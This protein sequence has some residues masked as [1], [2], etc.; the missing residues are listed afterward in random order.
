[1]TKK[2]LIEKFTFK[3]A[4]KLKSRK[5]IELLFKEGKSFSNF[6]FRV[7]YLFP[8]KNI[9]PLQSGFAVSTKNFKKAINRNRIKRLMKEAYRLQKNELSNALKNVNKLMAVFFIYTG[10]SIP[11]HVE[12]SEKIQAALKRLVKIAHENPVANS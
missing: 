7:L 2:N 3:K 12:V 11:G 5:L 8:D 9:S 4:E 1:M 6:P 10:S